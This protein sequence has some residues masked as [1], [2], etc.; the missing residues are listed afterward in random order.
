MNKK[1]AAAT[2]IVVTVNNHALAAVLGVKAG[3]KIKVRCKNGVPVTRE[4]RNRIKD[5][6]VDGCV[7]IHQNTKK[8]AKP[9]EEPK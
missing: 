4:W 6:K 8:P 3:D 1:T 2:V 5:A 7:T 9:T